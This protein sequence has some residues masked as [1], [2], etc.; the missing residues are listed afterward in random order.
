[1]LH[2]LGRGHDAEPTAVAQ[3]VAERCGL[4]PQTVAHTLF[5]RPPANDPDLVNLAHKL[6][7]IERQVAQS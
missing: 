1:M 2:R 4:D 6:D 3:A 7:N 5:G